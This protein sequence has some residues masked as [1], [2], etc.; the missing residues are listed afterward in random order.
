MSDSVIPQDPFSKRRR[1]LADRPDSVH[2]SSTVTV[3]DFYGNLQTWV[4]ETFRVD[5]EET[6]F[7]NIVTT[8]GAIRVVMPPSVTSKLYA[9]REQLVTRTRR[10]AAHTA[11][12]TRRERGDVLGNPDALAKARAARRKGRKR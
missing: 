3:V 7:V 2:A 1:L 8:E 12:A 10:R 4:F 9:Q 11:V 6:V 5:G